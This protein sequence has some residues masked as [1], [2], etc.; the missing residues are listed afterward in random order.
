VLV[1]PLLALSRL[2]H[3]PRSSPAYHA[4]QTIKC[5]IKPY[6][7]FGIIGLWDDCSM[8]S[9]NLFLPPFMTIQSARRWSRSSKRFRANLDYKLESLAVES[10]CNSHAGSTIQSMQTVKKKFDLELDLHPFYMR[11]SARRKPA[12]DNRSTKFGVDSSSRFLF[13]AWTDRQT[14]KRRQTNRQT[15]LKALSHAGGYTAGIG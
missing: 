2:P 3:V 5:A 15:E 9:A 7:L 4:T 11:V 14:D 8:I 13:R 10:T 12:M 6:T 1:R